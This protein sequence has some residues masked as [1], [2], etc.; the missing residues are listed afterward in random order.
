MSDTGQG[1]SQQQGGGLSSTVLSTI[2]NIV[3]AINGL[4]QS[5]AAAV[6]RQIPVF[7]PSGTAHST[8]LVPDPGAVAGTSKFLREDATFVVPSGSGTAA[9]KTIR[10]N[11][12]GGVAVDADNT[13]T[14]ILD[15]IIGTTR[16]NIVVRGASVWA[17]LALGSNT[18]VLQSNGTDLAYATLSTS[19]ALISYNIYTT[20]QTITI[21]AGATK[22]LVKL[23]GA[24]GGSGYQASV[25]CVNNNNASAGQPGAALQKFLSGL[26]PG[27]T[28]AL[29]I[30]AT[31]TTPWPQSTIAGADHT[32]GNGGATTL[33]S[34]SQTIS[35]LT[36]NGGKGYPNGAVATFPASSGGD[37]N[38]SYGTSPFRIDTSL[39]VN[40]TTLNLF[41][42]GINGI[43]EVFG[44]TITDTTNQIVA[45]SFAVPGAT[46][47]VWWYS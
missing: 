28:L 8:G 18:Q 23:R 29:T 4:S 2:Q 10:S 46:A 40:N 38:W 41:G 45:G 21:P 42:V 3:T 32:G 25:P 1:P 26:T 19:G 7:G 37:T 34:G 17:A 15:S 36:V 20:S 6:T 11:I 39:L 47:E 13:L 12:S 35:T 16:G 24:W 5:I 27:L 30:G 44:S 31:G 9:D 43:G 33:A 22:A 14:A